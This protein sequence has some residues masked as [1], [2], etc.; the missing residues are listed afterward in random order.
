MAKQRYRT[1]FSVDDARRLQ[2]AAAR[3]LRSCSYFSE[4]GPRLAEFAAGAIDFEFG[5]RL[6]A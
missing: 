4:G 3:R 6:F 1:D 5:N 2:F